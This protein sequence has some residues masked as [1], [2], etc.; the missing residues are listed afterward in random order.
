ML[1][2]TEEILRQIQEQAE[3]AYPDECCGAL[4]GSFASGRE[5][6]A[7]L[8]L[9]IDNARESGERYHRFVITPEDFIRAERAARAKGLDVIGFYHSHPDHPAVPSDYDREYALPVYS[10]V[11]TAAAKGKAGA[12]AS[13]LLRADRS[14]FEAEEIRT[15]S[16][17]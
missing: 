10:Y 1:V 13:W 8:I 16:H 7:R 2:M 15:C 6:E 11:I 14:A 3:A 17:R 12:S 5:R 9:P 4:I